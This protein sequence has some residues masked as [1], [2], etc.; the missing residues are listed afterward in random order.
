M[1]MNP[2]DRMMPTQEQIDEVLNDPEA[3]QYFAVENKKRAA[4]IEKILTEYY[5][6]D[7]GNDAATALGDLLCNLLHFAEQHEVNFEAA[8]E[9][10]RWH[11]TWEHVEP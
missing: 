9:N 4:R 7:Q 11:F 8:L 10:G 5:D 3:L 1:T 2:N 6:L